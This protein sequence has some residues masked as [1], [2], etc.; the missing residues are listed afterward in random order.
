MF[1]ILRALLLVVIA[2]GGFGC[3]RNAYT[4]YYNG[5]N[6]E[7]IQA[8]GTLETCASPVLLP[9][10]DEPIDAIIKRMDAD[11][12]ALIGRSAWSGRDWTNE[13]E[14]VAHA[15]SVG[16]CAA[17]WRADYS[18]TNSGVI[19]SQQYIPGRQSTTYVYGPGGSFH[20]TAV[21]QHPGTYQTRYIPYSVNI[22]RYNG[23][24]F[25]KKKIPPKPPLN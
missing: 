7:Q 17:M 6:L 16:A 19:A 9:F 2:A 15:Q 25:A 5:Q 14:A 10:P 22:Y 1:Y 8:Q 13:S 20:G 12:Y 11:G 3:V 24:F 21:T 23:L 4:T 18:H